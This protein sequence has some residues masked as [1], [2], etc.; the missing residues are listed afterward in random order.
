MGNFGDPTTTIEDRSENIRDTLI[1]SI[2]SIGFSLSCMRPDCMTSDYFIYICLLPCWFVQ[3]Y[4]Y[5]LS[6]QAF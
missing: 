4:K 2:R 1:R 3:I 6:Q 5:N